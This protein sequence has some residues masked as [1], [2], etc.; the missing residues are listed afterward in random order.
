[1]DLTILI[2]S[3]GALIL[4][5]AFAL[6]ETNKLSSESA[7]YDGLNLVGGAPFTAYARPLQSRLFLVLNGIWTLVALRDVLK[8]IRSPRSKK[9]L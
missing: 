8:D 7:W 2:G 4:L 9:F 5:V 1:M 6:L 3:L